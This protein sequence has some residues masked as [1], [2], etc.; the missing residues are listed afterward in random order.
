LIGH[1][2][3]PQS[4]CSLCETGR[5]IKHRQ[6]TSRNIETSNG[7]YDDGKAVKN[8]ADIYIYINQTKKCLK[9]EKR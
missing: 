2:K 6:E 1:K 4:G 7:S 5:K 3:C 9:Q 8:Q